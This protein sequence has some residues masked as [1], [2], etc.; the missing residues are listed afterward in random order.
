MYLAIGNLLL[1]PDSYEGCYL[2]GTNSE[3]GP[4][5]RCRRTMNLSFSLANFNFQSPKLSDTDFFN[6]PSSNPM[7]GK[8]KDK[9]TTCFFAHRHI[10]FTAAL[11]MHKHCQYKE[12]FN[13]THQIVLRSS[14]TD[15]PSPAA[16]TRVLMY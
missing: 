10:S 1:Y 5:G 2:E 4:T 9:P 13:E 16:T 3:N 6:C 12:R 7:V 15:N 14:F 8:E 11:T